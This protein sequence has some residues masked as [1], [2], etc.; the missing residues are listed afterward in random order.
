MTIIFGQDRGG[1]E[2][3]DHRRNRALQKAFR[4]LLTVATQGGSATRSK[5]GGARGLQG[6]GVGVE[7]E[8]GFQGWGDERSEEGKRGLG[9]GVGGGGKYGGSQWGNQRGEGVG[10]EVRGRGMGGSG[11]GDLRS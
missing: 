3:P 10:V 5:E 11:G 6:Q 1:G 4:G 2:R 8:G 7:R 9:G